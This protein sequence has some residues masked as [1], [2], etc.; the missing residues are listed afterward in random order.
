MDNL[1]TSTYLHMFSQ[2][3]GTKQEPLQSDQTNEVCSNNV[4]YGNVGLQG[5]THGHDGEFS[6]DSVTDPFHTKDIDTSSDLSTSD[7][8]FSDYDQGKTEDIEPIVIKPIIE[9]VQD[10]NPK[11]ETIDIRQEYLKNNSD[12]KDFKEQAPVE[13]LELSNEPKVNIETITVAVKHEDGEKIKEEILQVDLKR[14]N[15]LC[16][17]TPGNDHSID[18][19]KMFENGLDDLPNDGDASEEIDETEEGPQTEIRKPTQE[20]SLSEKNKTAKRTKFCYICKV[21]FKNKTSIIT[22][23]KEHFEYNKIKCILCKCQSKN[24]QGL[25]LHMKVIH[26]KS[27]YYPCGFCGKEFEKE[28]F[29][30]LH[31]RHHAGKNHKRKICEICGEKVKQAHWTQHIKRHNKESYECEKCGKVYASPISFQQHPCKH[32]ALKPFTCEHCGEAFKNTT[33]L[34]YH[35]ES[36]QRENTR[37]CLICSEGF[38]SPKHLAEHYR[39][40]HQGASR[41]QCDICQIKFTR[42][43]QLT[44]HKE[45]HDPNRPFPC[46][47]CH[48]RFR[49]RKQMETH[50]RMHTAETP[51][52]CDICHMTFKYKPTYKSHLLRVHDK[53]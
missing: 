40:S 16:E 32:P 52:S 50:V 30:N 36:H 51:F 41:Y 39:K 11:P 44:K 17:D 42:K 20:S 27:D 14:E 10:S 2:Q 35:M 18:S 4:H 31:F 47:F 33:Q 43:K 48:A 12:V 25:R 1:S 22:H 6:F 37:F 7:T 13:Q 8:N 46:N 23:M 24:V 19:S 53:Q 15:G 3:T 49:G 28:S 29:L 21:Q 9:A 38:N 26:F 5:Y 34:R 45:S